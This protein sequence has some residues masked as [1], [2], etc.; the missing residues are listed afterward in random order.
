M[1]AGWRCERRRILTRASRFL[2]NRSQEPRRF[3][4]PRNSTI[5][6]IRWFPS[7]GA[8]RATFSPDAGEG[9]SVALF[10]VSFVMCHA[11]LNPLSR[12]FRWT[13]RFQADA[14]RGRARLPAL[15]Q[16]RWRGRDRAGWG[17]AYPSRKTVMAF[18]KRSSR[19]SDRFSHHPLTQL[20]AI[21]MSIPSIISARCNAF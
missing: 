16:W 3:A 17:A 9:L 4:L 6:L 13:L 11:S 2:R 14:L 7:S 1:Q 19:E 8:Q 20:P 18:L 12:F 10:A 21:S 5:I 15:I